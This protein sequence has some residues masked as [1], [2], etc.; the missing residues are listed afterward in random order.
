MI[1]KTYIVGTLDTNCYVLADES[2]KEAVI[3]DPGSSGDKILESIKSNGWNAVAILLT[4]GHFDHIGGIENIKNQLNI[5]VYAH[6]DEK[7]ILE[8]PEG[9]LSHSFSRFNLKTVA[10]HYFNDD[11]I[12]QFG[13]DITLKMIH[14]PGHTPGGV[15]YYYEKESLLISGDT[16]FYLSIG[17]TDFPYGSLRDLMNSINN[18]LFT[19]PENTKVFPGHGDSTTIGFEKMNNPEMRN[20][21]D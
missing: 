7:T 5:P 21:W 1:I 19:L 15:C 2:T 16:L 9:N 20:L 3:I 8:N 14:T 11:F 13:A 12:F 18:R 17:R 10:D 4:H 6:Q